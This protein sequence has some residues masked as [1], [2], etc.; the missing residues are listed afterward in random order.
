MT[1]GGGTITHSFGGFT[2]FVSRPCRDAGSST[3]SSRHCEDFVL[4]YRVMQGFVPVGTNRHFSTY[5][6]KRS[7]VAADVLVVVRCVGFAIRHILLSGF[8]IS[9]AVET[10][11]SNTIQLWNFITRRDRPTSPRDR[12]RIEEPLHTL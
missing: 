1:K 8:V 9:F 6:V 5:F 4:L 2:R 3:V 7:P 10:L 11:F 12:R